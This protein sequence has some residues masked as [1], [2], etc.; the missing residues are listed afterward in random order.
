M[1]AAPPYFDFLIPERRAGRAGPDVHLGYWDAP[2]E[3]GAATLPGEFAAAQARLTK[4]VIDLLPQSRGGKFLDV[5]C[6]FGGT[7]AALAARRAPARLAGVNI[8]PRQLA[9][10]RQTAA[11]AA[12]VLADACRLPFA[13]GAFDHVLCV[14]AMF[15]FA[16]RAAFLAEAARVL[17]PGGTLV[18]T[19]MLMRPPQHLGAGELAGAL[20]I[21]RRDYG[22]W[23]DPWMEGAALVSAGGSAGLVL[24]HQ[25]DW[26]S[27]TQPS[28]R[29]IAPPETPQAADA[30]SIFRRWQAGGWLRYVAMVFG[31]AG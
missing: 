2:P 15:H 25:A 6:G 20:A 1:A 13:E 22:E 26:S 16:S 3:P 28:Y 27:N 8:D 30:G 31:K 4:R 14:E 18:V 11:G 9:L 23:P 29:W 21:V 10:C 12:L 5:A 19:D 17:R 7:L 24:Q